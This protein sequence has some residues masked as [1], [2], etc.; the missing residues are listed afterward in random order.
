M[1]VFQSND[2]MKKVFIFGAGAS[3]ASVGTPLGNGLVWDYYSDCQLLY[4]IK[5]DGKT[6]LT[7]VNEKYDNY[8][9]FLGLSEEIYPEFTSIKKKWEEQCKRGEWV[10]PYKLDKKHC[11][12][13][14]DRILQEKR[15]RLE[16]KRDHRNYPVFTV[17]DI[18]NLMKWRNTIKSE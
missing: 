3:N 9:N 5:A 15:E 13:E 1:T 11:V 12:D 10:L 7:E 8:S 6:D 4:E 18:E 17:L 2:K 16:P 14:M